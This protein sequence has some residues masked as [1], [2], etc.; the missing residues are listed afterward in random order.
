[1]LLFKFKRF[2]KALFWLLGVT[3]EGQ[4]YHFKS[5]IKLLTLFKLGEKLIEKLGVGHNLGRNP[6]GTIAT[7]SVVAVV[8]LL[9]IPGAQTPV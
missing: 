4:K 7:E 8:E 3:F 2:K 9:L 6:A 1:L 5:F